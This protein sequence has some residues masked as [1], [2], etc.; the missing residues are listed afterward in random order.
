MTVFDFRIE[1]LPLDKGMP[2]RHF[3]KVVGE[4]YADFRAGLPDCEPPMIISLARMEDVTTKESKYPNL[5]L[6]ET[7]MLYGI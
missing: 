1:S 5:M 7:R 2:L 3:R 6:L 4:A